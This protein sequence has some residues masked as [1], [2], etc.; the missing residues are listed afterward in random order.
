VSRYTGKPAPVLSIIFYP[1]QALALDAAVGGGGIALA[2][3]RLVEN[4]IKG[5]RLAVVQDTPL[6]SNKGYFLCYP[7][8]PFTEAK[9]VAFR[10]WI[11]GQLS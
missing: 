4:D 10:N 2:D 9:I 5:G 8:G 3:R 6:P 7:S 11:T 1:T